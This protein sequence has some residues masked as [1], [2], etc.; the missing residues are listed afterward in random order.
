[1]L[2]RRHTTDYQQKIAR[3]AFPDAN[4]Q[5]VE[6]GRIFIE[7]IVKDKTIK[8][9]EDNFEDAERLIGLGKYLKETKLLNRD[10][11]VS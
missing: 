3:I 11:T 4:I 2:E 10:S 7:S 1:M 9:I 6:D 8:E 5:D